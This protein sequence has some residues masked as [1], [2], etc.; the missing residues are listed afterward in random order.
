MYVCMYV[1]MCDLYT[2]IA[3]YIPSMIF[4]MN[5]IL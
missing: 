5:I 4:Y 2:S 3:I 1:C